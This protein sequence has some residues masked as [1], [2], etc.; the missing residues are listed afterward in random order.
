[1]S[2]CCSE[3]LDF[4]LTWSPPC[5]LV[6]AKIDIRYEYRLS[7][8]RDYR[9]DRYPSVEHS[10]DETHQCGIEKPWRPDHPPRTPARHPAHLQSRRL[11][12]RFAHLPRTP[13]LR[14]GQGYRASHPTPSSVETVIGCIL[15]NPTR[16]QRPS[17][18]IAVS[19]ATS[20][21]QAANSVRA[22]LRDLRL[23]VYHTSLS[24][25]SRQKSFAR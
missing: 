13:G 9:V 4:V 11:P 14:A 6:N 1:M 18:Q 7:S 20:C 22:R 12:W 10:V 24:W 5:V 16:L 23:S 19:D 25:R 21:G 8:R 15:V 17:S 2:T 3:D